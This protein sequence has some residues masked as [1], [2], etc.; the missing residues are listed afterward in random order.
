[1]ILGHS[2]AKVTQVYAERDIARGFE[3]ARVIG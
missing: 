3:V 2:Q 1:V